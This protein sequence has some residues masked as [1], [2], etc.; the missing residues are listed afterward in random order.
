MERN[1]YIP[2]P[3]HVVREP[4]DIHMTYS[5]HHFDETSVH[6]TYLSGKNNQVMDDKMKQQVPMIVYERLRYLFCINAA[7]AIHHRGKM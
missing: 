4:Q 2:V 3:A 7:I 1:Y 6:T 5:Y